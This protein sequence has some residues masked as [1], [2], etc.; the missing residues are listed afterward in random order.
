MCGCA[1]AQHNVLQW[2][3]AKCVCAQAI[4]SPWAGCTRGRRRR[5]SQCCARGGGLQGVRRSGDVTLT[6]RGNCCLIS[7]GCCTMCGGDAVRDGARGVAPTARARKRT[8]RT[9]RTL[10]RAAPFPV[11]ILHTSHSPE[12]VRAT[13]TRAAG[14]CQSARR[15]ATHLQTRAAHTLAPPRAHDSRS[16][17][18][19][20][21]TLLFHH[22]SLQRARSSRRCSAYCA[23]GSS[24]P[25]QRRGASGRRCRCRWRHRCAA[26]DAP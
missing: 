21:P 24:P 12:H 17:A 1:R 10:P 19:F 2:R 15:L 14:T 26:A 22:G 8:R 13:R 16:R 20:L 23:T 3:T 4:P 18:H 9:R 6:R 25:L 7:G 5:G 11:R